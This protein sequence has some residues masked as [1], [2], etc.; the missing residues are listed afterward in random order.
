MHRRMM[1]RRLNF[2]IQAK[3][4]RTW[5]SQHCSSTQRSALG[6]PV[7]QACSEVGADDGKACGALPVLRLEGDR[8]RIGSVGP[9]PPSLKLP[10]LH[11]LNIGYESMT[12]HELINTIFS[13]SLLPGTSSSSK[14]LQTCAKSKRTWVWRGYGENYD[15]WRA[16]RSLKPSSLTSF[17]GIP[18][19]LTK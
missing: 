4:S 13:G 11:G 8:L 12:T 6:F 5:G 10:A 3:R 9:L 7:D 18:G 14:W 16:S 1:D 15:H 19:T 17:F 2:G